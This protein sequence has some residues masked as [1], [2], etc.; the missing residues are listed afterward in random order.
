M[1]GTIGFGSL[2]ITK[3]PDSSSAQLMQ[4][5]A[6]NEG[7]YST[8]TRRLVPRYTSVLTHTPKKLSLHTAEDSC[9]PVVY[10]VLE[11][12]LLRLASGTDKLFIT[13]M[14]AIITEW[15]LSLPR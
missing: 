14:P 15:H 7:L 5:A 11:I 4:L 6:D 8:S 12:P 2:T 3:K 1:L 10:L 13:I 9:P